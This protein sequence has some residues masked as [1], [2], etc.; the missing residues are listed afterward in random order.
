MRNS[1]TQRIDPDPI[2]FP[3]GISSVA[4]RVHALGL[5]IG[6][7]GDTGTATRSGFPGS[8]GMEVIDAATFNEWGINY[9]KYDSCNVPGNW[10][11]SWQPEDGDWYN[12]NSAVRYCQMGGALAQQCRPIQFTLCNWGNA[13]VQDWEARVGH[14]WRMSSDSRY[15]CV[16][17][18]S[19][20]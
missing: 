8:L 17:I 16:V 13:D 10:S 1:T 2:K 6:I 4:D 19:R 5:K 3:D 14:S 9:L 20:N 11:D 15:V 12:S 7:Y 18:K